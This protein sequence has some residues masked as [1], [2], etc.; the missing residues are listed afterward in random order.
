MHH[1]HA[2]LF[3]GQHIAEA[4]PNI[5]PFAARPG[6]QLGFLKFLE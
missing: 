1:D 2:R 3:A 6:A 4:D 5:A